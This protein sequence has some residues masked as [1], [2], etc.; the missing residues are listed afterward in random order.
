MK[1]D[2]SART[3]DPQAVAAANPSRPIE[4]KAQKPNEKMKEMDKENR[5]MNM[6]LASSEHYYKL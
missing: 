5:L 2:F 6:K 4:L 3:L 1:D